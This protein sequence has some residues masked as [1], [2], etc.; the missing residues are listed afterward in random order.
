MNIS[1]ILFSM[2]EGGMVA[3]NCIKFRFENDYKWVWALYAAVS[4]LSGLA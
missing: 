1:Y 4:L 2:G 3:F